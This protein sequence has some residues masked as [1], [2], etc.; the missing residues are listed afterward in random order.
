[1]G[2]AGGMPNLAE[3]FNNP[4]LMNM[5]TQMMQSGAFDSIMRDPSFS[6]MYAATKVGY[7]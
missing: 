6:Q 4:G 2:G 1:M 3:L 7:I 5:A